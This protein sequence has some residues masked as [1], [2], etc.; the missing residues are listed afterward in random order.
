MSNGPPPPVYD[1]NDEWEEEGE[2]YN[3]GRGRGR[4]RGR[5]RGYYGGGRRSGYGPDYG[6]GGRGGYG[7][8]YGGRGGY[9]EEQDEYY[10]GEP[11]EYAPPARGKRSMVFHVYV[12]H[13]CCISNIF[14]WFCRAWQGKTGTFPW[15]RPWTCPRVLLD[16]RY[17]SSVRA[18]ASATAS[19]G[20]LNY[21]VAF[22]PYV[23]WCFLDFY[24]HTP[25][26]CYL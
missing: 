20:L 22:A 19:T 8:G 17:M 21:L 11:E 6:Y 2:Y 4:S 10:D 23:L 7:Y 9:Y 24:H 1:Y 5:G 26:R 25:F 15:S 13:A 16:V 12:G 14:Y 3:R 18:E